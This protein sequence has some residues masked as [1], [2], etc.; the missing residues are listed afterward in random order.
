[1]KNLFLSGNINVGKSTIIQYLIEN[2][3]I[4]KEE[5]GGFYTRAY[6]EN[7]KVKG[8]Y[9]DPINFNMESLNIKDRLIGYTPDDKRWIGIDDTFESLGVK[10]LDHCI[11]YPFKL[12]VM[13]ELGFFENNAYTFQKKVH[14]AL[15]CDKKIIGVIKPI[16][17]IFMDSIRERKD[18]TEV[19]ITQ[20]N[21]EAMPRILIEK[22][23]L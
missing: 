20:N 23:K 17:T 19:E 4:N 13:D 8:F 1:M 11:K 16:S 18:V 10:V 3:H 6:L 12:I 5:I 14:E 9:I 7:D 15:S 2:L 22:F 21:R